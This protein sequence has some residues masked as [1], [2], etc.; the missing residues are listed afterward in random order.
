MLAATLRATIIRVPGAAEDSSANGDAA[1]KNPASLSQHLATLPRARTVCD[2]E[3]DRV[4]C[5]R[6]RAG[7]RGAVA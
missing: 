1:D 5:P 7:L 2:H 3:Q 6:A 4:R